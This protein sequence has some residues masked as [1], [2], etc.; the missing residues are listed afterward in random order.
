MEVLHSRDQS[1]V[2]VPPDAFLTPAGMLRTE[3]Q[4]MGTTV[5]LLNPEKQAQKAT[6][7]I[8]QLF[9]DWEQVLSRFRPESELS[10]LNG[11]VG[12]AVIVSPLLFT[13]LQAALAAAKATGGIYDPT[14]LKQLMQAGYDRSFEQL[15]EQSPDRP[16]STAAPGGNWQDIHLDPLQRRV[17]L[18]AGIGIDLGGIAKGMAVDA[19]INQLQA[20]SLDAALVN[21]GGDLAIIGTPPGTSAW[22]LAVQGKVTSWVISL[23]RGAL[24][25]SSISR[26][27]WQQGWHLRHHLIDPR[28]GEPAQSKLWSVTVAAG[29]CMQAEV[30]AKVAFILGKERGKGFLVEQGLAGL[31]VEHDGNWSATDNWPR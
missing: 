23:Q 17:T 3:F 30:A 28:T 20:L 19:A 22:P 5:T 27:H 14:L 15:P 18:P 21:A 11:S 29:Q 6:T 10:R 9:S 16:S 12:E 13:V 24:A 2:P 1:L 7:I 31:L 8:R 26:R 25:T 4:A